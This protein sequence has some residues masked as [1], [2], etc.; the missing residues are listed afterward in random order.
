MGS[1]LT[2]GTEVLLMM[3]SAEPRRGQVLTAA[4]KESGDLLYYV[5][6]NHKSAW[7]P[8]QFVYSIMVVER[9]EQRIVLIKDG[10]APERIGLLLVVAE[11]AEG[12]KMYLIEQEDGFRRKS[13]EWH[14]GENLYFIQ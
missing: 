1:V 3:P 5:D 4:K 10:E 12:R 8:G 14:D 2:R 6:S 11:N 13:E 9:S 7:I